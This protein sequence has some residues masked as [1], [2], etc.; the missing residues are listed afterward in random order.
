VRMSVP[1]DYMRLNINCGRTCNLMTLII[2]RQRATPRRS[3]I[4]PRLQL[5]S[6]EN[7]NK[8]VDAQSR[9]FSL[10]R[11]TCLICAADRYWYV[12][13]VRGTRHCVGLGALA[14]H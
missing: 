6:P 2:P 13:T 1:P 7:G 8:A 11:S 3:G 10:L 9:V 12:S 5:I 14:R 4:E